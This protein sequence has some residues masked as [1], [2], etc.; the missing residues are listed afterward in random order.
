M[1]SLLKDLSTTVLPVPE[2]VG[3]KVDLVGEFDPPMYAFESSVVD[4]T[5]HIMLLPWWE[6]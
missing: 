4:S 6:K 1:I 3:W 2:V 5:D